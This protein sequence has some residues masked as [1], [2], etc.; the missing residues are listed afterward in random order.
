MEFPRQ[1]S[2]PGFARFTRSRVS[3][4]CHNKTLSQRSSVLFFRRP[5]AWL[6]Q[7]S[8]GLPFEQIL[9]LVALDLLNQ[10][11]NPEGVL[12][13]IATQH[14]SLCLYNL[15]ECLL[16]QNRNRRRSLLLTHFTAIAGSVLNHGFRAGTGFELFRISDSGV[17]VAGLPLKM[18]R[19]GFA[20]SVPTSSFA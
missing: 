13:L 4:K 16:H 3:A 12:G 7:E 2:L 19:F 14:Q 8:P 17:S 9:E 18:T 10:F 20:A 11:E 5:R 15:R 1:Q 6:R